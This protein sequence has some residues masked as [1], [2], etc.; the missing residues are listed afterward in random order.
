MYSNSFHFII[1]TFD[2]ITEKK[3]GNYV[4]VTILTDLTVCKIHGEFKYS[5]ETSAYLGDKYSNNVGCVAIYP[6]L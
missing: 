5:N 4:S 6:E 2:L 3:K 1:R